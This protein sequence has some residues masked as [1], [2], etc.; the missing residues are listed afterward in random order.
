MEYGMCR[1]FQCVLEEFESQIG[2][3]DRAIHRTF[4]EVFEITS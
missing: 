2:S 4:V 3:P 1:P